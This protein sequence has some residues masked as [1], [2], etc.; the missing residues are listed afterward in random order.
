M[1]NNRFCLVDSGIINKRLQ[2]SNTNTNTVST[3]LDL[4]RDVPEVSYLDS[5]LTTGFNGEDKVCNYSGLPSVSSYAEKEDMPGF[6]GTWD[7]LDALG[8][9]VDVDE[10][11]PFISSSMELV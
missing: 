6:E 10:N 8:W 4:D 2:M 3:E 9:D 5:L 11:G 1:Y 7:G